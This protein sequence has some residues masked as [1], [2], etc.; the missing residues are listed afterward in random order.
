MNKKNFIITIFLA[1]ITWF[2]SYY[3][4]GQILN[5]KN[6]ANEIVRNYNFDSIKDEEIRN[7][8]KILI[9]SKV[10][11]LNLKTVNNDFINLKNLKGE[12]YILEFASTTCEAC[13]ETVE[14]LDMLEKKYSDI[15][16]IKI[17]PTEDITAINN[18]YK[19]HN[20]NVPNYV[21]A[22]QDNRQIDFFSEFNIKFYP[23][24]LFVKDGYIVE[25]HVGTLD[26]NLFKHKMNAL[27]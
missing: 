11:D 23:T 4:T 15:K 13:N 3:I 22:G 27:K 1:L 24:L 8:A 19:K 10:S 7:L 14:T 20:L 25:M 18:F 5:N 17:F 26:E 16:F 6:K 21:I 12:K 9:G 2:V